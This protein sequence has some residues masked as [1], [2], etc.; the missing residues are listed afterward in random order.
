MGTPL[1]SI[2]VQELAV[3]G[4]YFTLS[5]TEADSRGWRRA[6]ALI[7]DAD[8]L[9]EVI[10]EVAARLGTTQRWI[11]A[12][13][14]YQ[15]W[16]ARLTSIYAGSAVTCGAV[17]DL[18]ADLVRYRHRR[19]GPVDLSVVQLQ[20]L[21]T[22]AGWRHLHDGHLAPLAAA[23]RGQVR[24]GG[25]L[26]RGNLASALAGALGVLARARREP[27]DALIGHGWAQPADL[28]PCGLWV[29][30]PDGPRYARA[31]CCGYEQ[32]EHG[33]RCGDCSLN[34]RRSLRPGGGQRA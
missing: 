23:I 3:I 29:P 33:G 8:H 25:Y 22:D 18:R 20:P 11:A 4:P 12:S 28:A 1:P 32:L 7:D 15:G 10:G 27:L 2:P 5:A 30:G 9:G 31:T 6:S 26:L 24:I 21:T 34:W 13:V 17:P 16:A 14:F 19:S